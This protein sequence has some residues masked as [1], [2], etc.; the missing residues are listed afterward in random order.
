LFFIGIDDLGPHI[1]TTSPSGIYRSFNAYAL[2]KGEATA[3]EYLST[4]YKKNLSFDEI[5]KLTLKAL[6]ESID[7]DLTKENIRLAYVKGEEN[8][9]KVCSKDE[10]DGFI[11]AMGTTA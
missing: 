8:K 1:Y 9:F 6:K 2:G 5:I 11:K 10:I 7:E 4:N 3:R